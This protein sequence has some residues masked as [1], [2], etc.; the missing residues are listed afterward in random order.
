MGGGCIAII[1][2]PTRA[3]AFAIF[4]YFLIHIK[5]CSTTI[6]L[7]VYSADIKNERHKR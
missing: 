2:D 1:W 3:S 4:D 6:A 5:G 7:N